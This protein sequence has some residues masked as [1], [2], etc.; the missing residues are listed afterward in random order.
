MF[1][2]ARCDDSAGNVDQ[3]RA[4]AAGANVNAEEVDVGSPIVENSMKI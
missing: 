2:G 3:Q 1:F 4:C